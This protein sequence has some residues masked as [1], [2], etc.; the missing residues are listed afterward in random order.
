VV[1]GYLLPEFGAY[2]PLEA[3]TT[4]R[5][6]AYRERL[7]ADGHLSRRS[8]QKVLVPM[9]C[10]LKRAKR[11]KWIATNPSEDVERVRSGAPA[12]STC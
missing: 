12:T 1:N 6:E 8:P 10:I 5:I 3:I 9:H 4:E 11:R 7:P 2:T